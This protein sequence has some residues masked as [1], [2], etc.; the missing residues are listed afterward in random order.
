MRQVQSDCTRSTSISMLPVTSFIIATD[1]G[2]G[3]PLQHN[4]LDFR[5]RPPRCSGCWPHRDGAGRR[6]AQRGRASAR[7][8]GRPLA[9]SPRLVARRPDRGGGPRRPK[10]RGSTPP[11]L[12]TAAE[13]R[14]HRLAAVV[15]VDV[16]AAWLY[17]LCPPSHEFLPASQTSLASVTTTRL[18]LIPRAR[19]PP[20]HGPVAVQGHTRLCPGAGRGTP[21]DLGGWVP[22]H[23]PCHLPSSRASLRSARPRTCRGP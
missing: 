5:K 23:S 17:H 18:L 14:P 15:P 21:D 11:T 3:V 6:R 12:G 7:R 20:R 9:A 10:G 2:T 16:L 8:A 1:V 22:R 4:R 19:P 13:V